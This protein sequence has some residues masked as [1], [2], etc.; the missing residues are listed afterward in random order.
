LRKRHRLV[1]SISSGMADG[2]CKPAGLATL[3]IFLVYFSAL[4]HLSHQQQG[5]FT[6]Y[7]AIGMPVL[8]V[9]IPFVMY[10]TRSPRS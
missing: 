7:M 4:F 2:N 8:V 5:T 6:G 3:V 9:W 1:D 10:Y